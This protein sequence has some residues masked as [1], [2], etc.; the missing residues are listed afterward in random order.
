MRARADSGG[1]LRPADRAQGRRLGAGPA[2]AARAVAALRAQ[3][4]Q[5]AV[6]GAEVKVDPAGGQHGREGKDEKG[7]HQEAKV[8]VGDQWASV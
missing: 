6:R 1:L 8:D 4:L 3:P 2:E 7:F 5:L